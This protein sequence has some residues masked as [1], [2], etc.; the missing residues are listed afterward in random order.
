MSAALG[1][2]PRS[3]IVVLERLRLVAVDPAA[4]TVTLL[5]EAFVPRSDW[6]QM[7]AFLGERGSPR[8]W[9]LFACLCCWRIY[10]F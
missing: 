2:P 1:V 5:L 4:D 8:R 6:A 7:V 10:H 9:R 3:R